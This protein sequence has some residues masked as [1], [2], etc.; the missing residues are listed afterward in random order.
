MGGR[1]A[2]MFSSEFFKSPQSP[3]LLW[4]LFVS[5]CPSVLWPCS[6]V[7]WSVSRPTQPRTLAHTNSGPMQMNLASSGAHKDPGADVGTWRT[8]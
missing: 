6:M 1:E 8:E 4:R 3:V 2:H 7:H 5:S